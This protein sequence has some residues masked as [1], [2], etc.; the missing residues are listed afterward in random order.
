M[1]ETWADGD[2]YERF[3]GRWS[4]KVA[5]AF[6]DWLAPSPGLRWADLGCGSGALTAAILERTSPASV[7]G[8]DP[9]PRQVTE[10]ARRITDERASFAC[11]GAEDLEARA[12]DVVVSGLVLNFVPDPVAAARAMARA[13]QGGTVAAYVWDYASGMQMLRTF[14]DVAGT[15]DPAVADLH[16]GHRFQISTTAAL[17]EIWTAAGIT[18]VATTEITVPTV[19]ADFDD[20]WTP[21]LGGQGPAPGYVASLDDRARD[22]LRDALEQRLPRAHDGSIPLSA[23]VWT[24]RGAAL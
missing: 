1:P 15:L 9:A 23:R 17:S 13:A 2:A 4:R 6:L 8:V 12:F 21:F 3:M 24:V 16:E 14:W 22:R 11:A 7:L 19:F 5:P 20:F 18:D 10:A